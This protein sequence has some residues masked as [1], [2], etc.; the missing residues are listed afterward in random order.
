MSINRFNAK[1]DVNE[2]EIVE[3]FTLAGCCVVRI[4]TPMDLLVSYNGIN[5]L[6]EVKVSDKS[7]FTK[8]QKKF[9]AVWKG[10]WCRVETVGQA[11]D[12]VR[13]LKGQG[14]SNLI[15]NSQE[16]QRLMRDTF[17]V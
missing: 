2:K 11:L 12:V 3:A 17:N 7:T 6:V 13:E 10:S 1:R 8:N 14:K 5:I 4:D 9:I 15:T 16:I